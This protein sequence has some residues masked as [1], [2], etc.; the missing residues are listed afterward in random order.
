M[1]EIGCHPV[2]LTKI[3]G[4]AFGN[5]HVDRYTGDLTNT[6]LRGWIEKLDYY[7]LKEKEE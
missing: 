2:V 7:Q 4:H 3:S 1:A 6:T 5:T